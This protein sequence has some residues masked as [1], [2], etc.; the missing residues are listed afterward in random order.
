ML[1][2]VTLP[3]EYTQK[4]GYVLTPGMVALPELVSDRSVLNNA[5]RSAESLFRNN[6]AWVDRPKG[7]D[8]LVH[9]SWWEPGRYLNKSIWETNAP[10]RM[11][12]L[13]DCAYH[14]IN[15]AQLEPES[16]DTVSI[17][18]IPLENPLTRHQDF[19]DGEITLLLL[20]GLKNVIIEHPLL[21]AETS[22]L[23]APGDAYKLTTRDDDTTPFHEAEAISYED[24][25]A[26]Y[27]AS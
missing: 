8:D 25:L 3:D 19:H 23:Q 24:T 22:W 15:F 21:V 6:H 14:L 4:G 27:V 7:R 17:L 1:E 10:A 18:R 9:I 26:M 5:R 20:T 12:S 16:V 11:T 2:A 13:M